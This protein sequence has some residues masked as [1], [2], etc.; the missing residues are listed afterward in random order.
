MDLSSGRELELQG[1]DLEELASH[2]EFRKD[3]VRSKRSP[4]KHLIRVARKYWITDLAW[5]RYVIEKWEGQT[6]L[7]TTDHPGIKRSST[8]RYD[9]WRGS[10]GVLSVDTCSLDSSPRML[11]RRV[12]TIDRLGSKWLVLKVRLFPGLH[13]SS[14][15]NLMK[16]SLQF[17]WHNAAKNKKPTKAVIAQQFLNTLSVPERSQTNYKLAKLLKGKLNISKESAKNYVQTWR[18]SEASK[19]PSHVTRR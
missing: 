11:W 7:P 5:L 15:N 18:E 10:N 1:T 3:V 8:Y 2:A 12:L 4:S 13:A 17:A 16:E 19:T 14:L 6:P 9:L